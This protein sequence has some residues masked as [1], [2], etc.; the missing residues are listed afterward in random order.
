MGVIRTPYI[1]IEVFMF[2]NNKMLIILI[3]PLKLIPIKKF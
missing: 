2:T 1:E 3:E